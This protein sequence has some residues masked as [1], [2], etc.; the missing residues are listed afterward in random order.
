MIE[1]FRKSIAD[2]FASLGDDAVYRPVTGGMINLKI[3]PSINISS[4]GT[5]AGML[6]QNEST[7]QIMASDVAQPAIGDTY[8]LDGKTYRV[9]STPRLGV[10]QMIWF[11]DAPLAAEP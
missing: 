2:Q 7:S 11:L 8:E 3:I 9:R 5:A 10:H 6:V 1:A 4:H